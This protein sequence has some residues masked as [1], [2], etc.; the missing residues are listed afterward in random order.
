MRTRSESPMLYILTGRRGNQKTVTAVHRRSHVEPEAI[1]L[2][3]CGQ[4]ILIH[5]WHKTTLA[6]DTPVLGWRLMD[7]YT[8]TVRLGT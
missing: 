4:P 5:E 6:T 2:G 8:V 7:T 1:R 3:L